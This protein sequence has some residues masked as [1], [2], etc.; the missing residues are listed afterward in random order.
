MVV[1]QVVVAY[2]PVWAIGSGLCATPQDAQETHVLIRNWVRAK[3]SPEVGA[4]LRITYGGSVK[5]ATAEA[6]AKQPDID[7][8]LIGGAA[9]K[10]DFVAIIANANSGLLARA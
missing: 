6:L 4:A 3:V 2:E 1:V 5:G 10:E 9:L 7:G 8:F